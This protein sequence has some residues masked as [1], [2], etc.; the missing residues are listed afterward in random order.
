MV[1]ANFYNK[2]KI[3]YLKMISSGKATKNSKGEIIKDAIYQSTKKETARIEPSKN[4]FTNTKTITQEELEEYRGNIRTK[5][6]Y[7]VLISSGNVPYSLINNEV[8]VKRKIDYSDA[9]GMTKAKR[10]FKS[11]YKNMEDLK[12]KSIEMGEKFSKRTTPDMTTVD[13]SNIDNSLKNLNSKKAWNELYKVLDSSDVIVHVLDARDPMNTKCDQI[14][15]YLEDKQH[16]HLIYVLNKVDLVPTQVTAGWLRFLSKE[17]AAIA[18][19]A[20]SL[21][22]T[23]GKQNLMNVFRQLKTLYKKK[24]S[25]MTVGFVGYPNTGKS[26]IINSLRNKIVCSVAPV[27]GQTKSWQY[28]ALSKNMYVVDS[29]G[30]IPVKDYTQAVLMGAVQIEKIDEPDVYA[31]VVLENVGKSKIVST[32]KIENYESEEEFYI[33]YANKY[34]RFTKGREP[35][36]DLIARTILHDFYRGKLG[37]YKECEE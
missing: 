35:N 20:N 14:E 6:P 1:K 33:K 10:M 32:Y 4:W 12:E 31:N 37:Y 34:G 27:P 28:V 11:T 2:N 23:F 24:K 25:V 5:T 19:H 15:K 26:S 13:T 7:E 8:K 17:H 21:S 36:V 22:H 30:V 9:F 3:E 16:K 18:F 29:P